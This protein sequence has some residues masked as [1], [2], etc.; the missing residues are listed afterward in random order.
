MDTLQVAS[1]EFTADVAGALEE[2]RVSVKVVTT[3]IREVARIITS[4]W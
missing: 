1:L 2:T 4:L 3:V